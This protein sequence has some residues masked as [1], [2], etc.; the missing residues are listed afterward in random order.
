M[1]IHHIKK[2]ALLGAVSAIAFINVQDSQ[3]Q[4]TSQI[5]ATFSTAAAI[6]SANVTDMDFGTWAV[7][8]G[9]GDT[10]TI[11]QGAVTSGAPIVGTVGGA[12]SSVVSNTVA[13]AASGVINVT[14]P[15]ATTLQI[16]GNVTTDFTDANLSLSNIV[17]TDTIL[18]DTAVPAAYNGVTRATIVTG[19]IAEPI[20]FG[21]TLTISGTP[22]AGTVFSDAVIDISFT[23]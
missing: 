4:T 23:Y 20:G 8:I 17:F 5:G 15:V 16:E 1:K 19:G 12:G 18:T 14:A 13:P 6:T 7:N 10:P 11:T 21:G 3:A 22:T 9:G 2:L